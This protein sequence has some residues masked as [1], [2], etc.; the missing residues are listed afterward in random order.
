ME[1][2]LRLDRHFKV[3][4]SQLR[5][6]E[7]WACSKLHTR[8]IPVT[9][10]YLTASWPWGFYNMQLRRAKGLS[11]NVTTSDT[12]EAGEGPRDLVLLLEFSEG[13]TN[14]FPRFPCPR[15]GKLLWINLRWGKKEKK[16]AKLIEG[17]NLV[18]GLWI[19]L[20]TNLL[21]FLFNF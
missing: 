5:E 4:L 16:G 15:R 10:E 9:P 6:R 3:K 13:F 11:Q 21:F 20:G 14:T 8:H 19:T 17:G 1:A 2:A 12:L 18:G 7:S